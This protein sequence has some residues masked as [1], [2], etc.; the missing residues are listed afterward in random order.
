MDK[1]NQHNPE[2]N[3][4]K[5]NGMTVPEGYFDDFARRMMDRIPQEVMPA[6]APR[7]TLWMKVRPY[8]YM[9]AMFAGIWLMMNIFSLL[10]TTNTTTPTT[11]SFSSSLYSEVINTNTTGYLDDYLSMSNYDFYDDLYESGFEIPE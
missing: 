5:T 1:K 7:R 11:D 4:P 6:A 2:L 9:A 3:W 8:V 10:G